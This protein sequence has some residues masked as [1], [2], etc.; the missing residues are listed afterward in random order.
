ME[1]ELP[2]LFARQAAA[3][4]HRFTFHTARMR[5]ISVTPRPWRR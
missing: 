2:E 5:T 4:G 3:S 1:T